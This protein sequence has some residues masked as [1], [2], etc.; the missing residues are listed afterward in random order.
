VSQTKLFTEYWPIAAENVVT[1]LYAADRI[2]IHLAIHSFIQTHGSS[3]RPNS[4]AA[5]SRSNGRSPN[6]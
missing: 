6:R 3:R 5:R 1:G 4:P 2:S